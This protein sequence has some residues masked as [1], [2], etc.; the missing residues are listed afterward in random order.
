MNNLLKFIFLG[1]IF[2]FLTLYYGKYTA[3][4]YENK[5]VLTDEAILQFEKDLKE[6]KEIIPENYITKEKNYNNKI[7]SLGIKLSK[8]IESTFHKALKWIMKTLNNYSK[9]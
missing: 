7:S 1:T 5:K 9:E 6:G 8:W 4:Y 3:N 2:F